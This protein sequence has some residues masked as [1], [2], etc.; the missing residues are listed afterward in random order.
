MANFHVASFRREPSAWGGGEA[1]YSTYEGDLCFCFQ[2]R[3]TTATPFTRSALDFSGSLF[4]V[5]YRGKK[6]PDYSAL[7]D[8]RNQCRKRPPLAEL[9][10]LGQ[11]RPDAVCAPQSECPAI[12]FPLPRNPLLRPVP[13]G[14][15][16]S[17][18]PSPAP[19]CRLPTRAPSLSN[20]MSALIRSPRRLPPGRFYSS[21]ARRMSALRLSSPTGC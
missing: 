12:E 9:T 19:V 2:K 5:L 17:R 15:K 13:S 6:Y 1:K 4:H 21:R 7:N 10:K 11:I 16:R 18:S 3:R 14:P 8:G 20:R